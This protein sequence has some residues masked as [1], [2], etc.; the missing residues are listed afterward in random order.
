MMI[1]KYEQN[2]IYTYQQSNTHQLSR[3][4]MSALE[5]GGGEEK[6]SL[7]HL[8]HSVQDRVG[9][10]YLIGYL[11]NA[12][13]AKDK[14]GLGCL[15][16]PLRELYTTFRQNTSKFFQERRLIISLDGLTLLYNEM[17]TEKC[18]HNDLASVNDVQLLK[19]N[20]EKKKDKKLYCAFLPFGKHLILVI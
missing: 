20:Y 15:Q 8:N 1:S 10:V 13:L 4:A 2:K 9:P 12:I 16:S 6:T 17:G 14:T 7:N 18:I 5:R 3:S 19:L 11:G